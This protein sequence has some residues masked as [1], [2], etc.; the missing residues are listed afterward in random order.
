MLFFIVALGALV[1]WA[2]VATA[3]GLVRDGYRRIPTR[4]DAPT[5]RREV[6][7]EPRQSSTKPQL[8]RKMSYSR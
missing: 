1:I 3:I 2:V 6:A 7:E 4:S 8:H 5:A